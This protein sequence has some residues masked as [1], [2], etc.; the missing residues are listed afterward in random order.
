MF[1]EIIPSAGV[2]L[3]CSLVYFWKQRYPNKT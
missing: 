2:C 1:G 3:S